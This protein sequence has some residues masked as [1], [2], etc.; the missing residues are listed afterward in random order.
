M[1]LTATINDRDV[2]GSHQVRFATVT[3]DNSYPTGGEI[4]TAALFELQEIKNLVVHS[5]D[6]AKYRPVHVPATGAIKLYVEDGTSGIEAEAANAS[7]QSAVN[8]EVMV[9]GK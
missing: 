1:A 5:A 3:F 4:P 8:V 7:D 2:F 9:I 6:D